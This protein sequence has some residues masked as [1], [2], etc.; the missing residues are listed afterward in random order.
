MVTRRR[1]K[2]EKSFKDR[3]IEEATKFRDAAE[4]LPPG[5]QRELLIK[6][7]QQAERAAE[8]NDW[9]SAPGLSPPPVSLSRLGVAKQN[10]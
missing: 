1:V 2:H 10:D 7:V 6:R 3:L 5:T 4:R 9:L 8:M